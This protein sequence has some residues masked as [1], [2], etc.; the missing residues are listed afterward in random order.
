MHGGA[1]VRT[2]RSL[3]LSVLF[4]RT[5][6]KPDNITRKTG[7]LLSPDKKLSVGDFAE[8]IAVDQADAALKPASLT[9]E[10]AASVPLVGLTAW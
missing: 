6:R 7:H 4:D 1:A 5:R 9:M 2:G 3:P 10:E 8:R